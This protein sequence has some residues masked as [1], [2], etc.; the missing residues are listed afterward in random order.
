MTVSTIKVKIV[1]L[2]WREPISVSL[3]F[4]Q[5]QETNTFGRKVTKGM[6]ED[7]QSHLTKVERI[8]RTRYPELML[9]LQWRS[10]LTSHELIYAHPTRSSLTLA[11]D[12]IRTVDMWHW[13]RLLCQLFHFVRGSIIVQLVSS[14]T[15]LDLTKQENMSLFGSSKATE[16]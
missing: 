8:G 10:S 12:G 14:L 15:G 6:T 2:Y 1:A 16:S 5:F 7:D 11:D 9:W 4:S 13:M 3:K